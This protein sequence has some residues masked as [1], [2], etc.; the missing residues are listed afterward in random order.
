[1]KIRFFFFF[2]F[3]EYFVTLTWDVRSPTS[4]SN[5]YSCGYW[6]GGVCVWRISTLVR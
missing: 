1:M 2:K 6:G 3:R 5:P 4:T